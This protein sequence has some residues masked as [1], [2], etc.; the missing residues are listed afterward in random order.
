MEEAVYRIYK[1][2]RPYTKKEAYRNIKTVY[3]K[4]GSANSIVTTEARRLASEAY[5]KAN[6]GKSYWSLSNEAIEA[7]EER[8][9]RQFEVVKYVP[10]KEQ[11]K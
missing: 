8:A 11:N 10:E 5:K 4:K 6:P 1:N 9:R 7:M 2:G 3:V